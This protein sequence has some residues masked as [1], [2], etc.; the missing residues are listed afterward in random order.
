LVAA[1]LV[2]AVTVLRQP[3]PAEMAEMA[4]MAGGHQ[5]EH[6][7]AEAGPAFEAG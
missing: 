5:D 4:E 1:A 3:S 7:R 6:E 2:V